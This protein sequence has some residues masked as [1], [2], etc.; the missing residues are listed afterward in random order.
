M[1]IIREIPT[2]SN[3]WKNWCTAGLDHE[4]SAVLVPDLSLQAPRMLR[5]T[6]QRHPVVPVL[7][8]QISGPYKTLF[9]FHLI[10]PGSLP[11]NWRHKTFV[12]NSSECK[13][14]C[15]YRIFALV[16]SS[17]SWSQQHMRS[18][19]RAL[20]IVYCLGPVPRAATQNL[21][22]S[23]DVMHLSVLP[24]PHGQS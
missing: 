1:G 4:K 20:K 23:S 6:L 21:G 19:G 12:G 24:C 2:S 17:G 15:D 16:Q 9:L 13:A 22:T 3:T 14:L 8:E 5:W 10:T 11:S 18:P 7:K